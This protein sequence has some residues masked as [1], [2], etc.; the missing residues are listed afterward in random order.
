ML[1][2][3]NITTSNPDRAYANQPDKDMGEKKK[4]KFINNGATENRARMYT[5]Q[6]VMHA[7]VLGGKN[8]QSVYQKLGSLS[9]TMSHDQP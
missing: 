3:T 2:T 7:R 4:V 8:A 9:F 6:S 5:T 1:H